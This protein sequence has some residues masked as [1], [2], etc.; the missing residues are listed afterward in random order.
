MN[1][2]WFWGKNFQPEKIVLSVDD[3]DAFVE[4]LN[5]GPKYNENLVRLMQRPPPWTD[6]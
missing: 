5:E 6:D 3:F 4:R 1:Q 2:E